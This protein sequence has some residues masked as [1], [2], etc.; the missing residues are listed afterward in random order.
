G[1]GCHVLCQ[2]IGEIIGIGNQYLAHARGLCSS[3]RGGLALMA[4][5]QHVHIAA[6]L[7]GCGD[8]VQGAGFQAGVVVFGNNECSHVLFLYWMTLASVLSLA[9]SSAASLTITPA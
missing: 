7:G 1:L 5:D 4:G 2:T 9:T 6:A 8:R 3:L